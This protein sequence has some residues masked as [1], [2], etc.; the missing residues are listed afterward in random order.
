MPC[1]QDMLGPPIQRQR[2]FKKSAI[3][4]NYGLGTFPCR[5]IPS[6]STIIKDSSAPSF[7]NKGP[8]FL[9]PPS[10]TQQDSSDGAGTDN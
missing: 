1:S 2:I 8:M 4:Y 6:F 5:R 10:I 9:V 3:V 7:R